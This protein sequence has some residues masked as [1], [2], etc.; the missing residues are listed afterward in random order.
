M[1]TVSRNKC[2]DP[3][4]R[5]YTSSWAVARLH[6]RCNTR[7]FVRCSATCWS[8]QRPPLGCMLCSSQH[9]T[10]HD[11]GARAWYACRFDST[12]G[13]GRLTVGPHAQ[14][15]G[16]LTAAVEEEAV[17][18][19]RS[20]CSARPTILSCHLH[21]RWL[22]LTAD[23]VEAGGSSAMGDVRDIDGGTTSK[24]NIAR[25]AS[26]SIEQTCAYTVV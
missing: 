2:S 20:R 17:R 15:S 11:K 23:P 22:P 1:S 8:P 13:T 25:V 6:T 19:P 16:R 21:C 26:K 18:L 3:S 12:R 14:A 5:A 4:S 9:H 10:I 7:S 24:G